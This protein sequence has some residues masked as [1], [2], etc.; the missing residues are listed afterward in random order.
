MGGPH[1]RSERRGE[2]KNMLPLPGIEPRFPGFQVRNLIAVMKSYP[3]SSTEENIKVR[4]Q[5]CPCA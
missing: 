5:R 3:G 1:N 2:E 4:K